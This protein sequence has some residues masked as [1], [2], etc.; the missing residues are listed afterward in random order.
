MEEFNCDIC[1]GRVIQTEVNYVCEECG[2]EQLQKPEDYLDTAQPRLRKRGVE[3]YVSSYS[4]SDYIGTQFK[5]SAKT[6]NPETKATFHRLEKSQKR[7]LKFANKGKLR[8]KR[9]QKNAMKVAGKTFKLLGMPSDVSEELFKLF[10]HIL[11]DIGFPVSKAHLYAGSLVWWYINSHPRTADTV[12]SVCRK[13]ELSDLVELSPTLPKGL[14]KVVCNKIQNFIRYNKRISDEG[15]RFVLTKFLNTI[16][17][18]LDDYERKLE[19][20]DRI[21]P[22]LDNIKN[23]INNLN[24]KNLKEKHILKQKGK[25][26]EDYE[27][28]RASI[29]KNEKKMM[30]LEQEKEDIKTMVKVGD[31]YYSV[32]EMSSP[33]DVKDKIKFKSDILLKEIVLQDKPLREILGFDLIFKAIDKTLSKNDIIK[34]LEKAHKCFTEAY[35]KDT[36]NLKS[37]L[38]RY[39]KEI[40]ESLQKI[41]QETKFVTVEEHIK[42]NIRILADK[43]TLRLQIAEKQ[44]EDKTEHF[45]QLEHH[46]NPVFHSEGKNNI[47]DLE[48]EIKSLN[49]ELYSLKGWE[50]TEAQK[51]DL[52]TTALAI[53]SH[54]DISLQSGMSR[55]ALSVTV[56]WLAL[57]Y[58]SVRISFPQMALM[59]EVS[60]STLGNQKNKIADACLFK[61]LEDTGTYG[62]LDHMDGVVSPVLSELGRAIPFDENNEEVFRRIKRELERIA[63]SSTIPELSASRLFVVKL[64]L[65]E[66]VA[67]EDYLLD[68]IERAMDN[69]RKDKKELEY[70]KIKAVDLPLT[71][72]IQ[73][74]KGVLYIPDELRKYVKDTF[75]SFN[76]FISMCILGKW[77]TQRCENSLLRLAKS[78]KIGET[79][80][81]IKQKAKLYEVF[82]ELVK[83]T[84]SSNR[85]EYV[86]ARLFAMKLLLL[87]ENGLTES[88]IR[89]KI[90]KTVNLSIRD[91]EE[92]RRIDY[93]AVR[94][95]CERVGYYN[96]YTTLVNKKGETF[97]IPPETKKL[98][99]KHFDPFDTFVTRCVLKRWD[100]EIC[101]SALD[102]LEHKIG[103]TKQIMNKITLPDFRKI[104]KK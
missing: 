44:L 76:Q 97:Y 11:N 98:I 93:Y 52:E 62:Y 90:K 15:M 64:L 39:R 7:T 22:K 74:K 36:N 41:E 94:F 63:V 59:L 40:E 16:Q 92:T 5:V 89:E 102:E 27:D 71:S 26:Y 1:G 25:S 86:C 54:F 77:D 58:H 55:P 19:V 30:D 56:I 42:K 60:E 31:V 72:I 4:S 24:R 82:D 21:K 99:K 32:F 8:K 48:T 29:L 43:I 2:V 6:V 67:P 28:I 46:P 83:I 68:K 80:D 66:K 87:N 100:A 45:F 9:K 37:I 33:V 12:F 13:V 78:E 47:K 73:K 17:R 23:Q 18:E 85:P 10:N 104:S 35:E 91:K 65:E 14:I 70:I 101:V 69:S 20:K 103:V 53:L 38:S 34:L 51:N 57:L 88:E 3:G 49:K 81:D 96:E 75:G 84:G 95:L 50:L 79:I 61:I